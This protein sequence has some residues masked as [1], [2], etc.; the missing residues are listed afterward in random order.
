MTKETVGGVSDES[1]SSAHLSHKC[2]GYL[3]DST[4]KKY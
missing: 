4:I 3:L 2:L 1:D